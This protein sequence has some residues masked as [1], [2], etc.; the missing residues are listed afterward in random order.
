MIF[1]V[2]GGILV[3]GSCWLLGL[4]MGNKGIAR[5]KALT[6]FK[7]C[8]NLL[9]SEI[10]FAA[11]PLPLAF[12]HIAQKA[13]H[14]FSDFFTGLSEKLSDKGADLTTAWD[15]GLKGMK[16][17]GMTQEDIR[18]IAGLGRALGSIDKAAQIK[19]IDMVSMTIDDILMRLNA[20]NA[21]DGKMYKKLG[22]LG[23]I[24]ITII[25]L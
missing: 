23:G 6:E 14:A 12:S 1:R 22:L 9:R 13:G 25:L 8:L 3:C 7:L 24:L 17:A 15:D 18:A 11:R 5:A 21:K 4:Y 2:L 16:G 20:A 19:A 10:E